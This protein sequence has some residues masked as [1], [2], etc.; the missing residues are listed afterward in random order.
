MNVSWYSVFIVFNVFVF[1]FRTTIK[2]NHWMRAISVI[3]VI[4]LKVQFWKLL[5]FY[6]FQ[7]FFPT[8]TRHIENGIWKTPC[9]CR[10]YWCGSTY[11]LILSWVNIMKP[12]WMKFREKLSVG[13]KSESVPPTTL[14]RDISL[15]TEFFFFTLINLVFKFNLF[16]IE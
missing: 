14:H 5:D 13:Q 4:I 11:E 9:S 2:S 3:M 1:M 6:Y 8:I 15:I 12:K 10:F 7:S 16:L